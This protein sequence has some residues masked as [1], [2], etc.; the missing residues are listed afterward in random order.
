MPF[1]IMPSTMKVVSRPSDPCTVRSRFCMP[2]MPPTSGSARR[3]PVSMAPSDGIAAAG[4][5][6]VEHARLS[7]C[8]CTAVDVSTTGD[9][10]DTVIVS[11]RAPTFMSPLMVAVKLLGSST[12]SRLTVLKPS[13]EKVTL[14]TPGRRSTML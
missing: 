2:D 10:P 3:A 12:P 8:C 9:W 1:R 7:T 5:D 13:S 11:S 14:Y 4:R 6:R